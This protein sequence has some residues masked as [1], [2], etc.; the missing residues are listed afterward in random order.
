MNND[1]RRRE[2]M[3]AIGMSAAALA[4]AAMPAAAGPQSAPCQSGSP[5]SMGARFREL[6]RSAEPVQCIAA[7]DPPSAR[8]V[9]MAGYPAIFVGGSDI[10]LVQ[11]LPDVGLIS[12]T[13]MTT[14]AA[15]II[16][17]TG[18]P[19]LADAD[20]GGGS[21]ASAYRTM[22]AFAR[23]GGGAVMFEDR[24]RMER[25]G[26]RADVVP[27]AEMVGRL[28]AAVDASSDPVVVA[29]CDALAA[30]RPMSETIDRGAA[31]AEAGAQLLFFAGLRFEDMPKVAAAVR[32]PLMAQM[33]ADT[34]LPR[35]RESRV[36]I[37]VY[38]SL[39]QDIA[40][41]AVHRAL[42]ELKTTG[43][44]SETAKLSTPRDVQSLLTRTREITDRAAK[45]RGQ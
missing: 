21:P 29:R 10:A 38:T 2:F 9:E 37:A 42:T 17:Q 40:L 5:R 22:V 36:T 26:Q 19:V 8:L 43:T 28:R 20:N 27:Q 14:F 35:A 44:M 30:G 31:Y 32:R 7:F 11:G 12:M 41:G 13:E 24:I 1:T 4:A 23:A 18:I 45:Y 16:E 33:L 25:I 3:Q 34:T 15:R 6:L 39:L